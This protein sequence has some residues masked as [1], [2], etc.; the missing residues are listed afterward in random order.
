M[1]ICQGFQIL[2][3][4]AEQR[5]PAVCIIIKFAE[6]IIHGIPPNIIVNCRHS[7]DCLDFSEFLSSLF[8]KAGKGIYASFD[9]DFHLKTLRICI[10]KQD[11]GA[12]PGS[13]ANLR[14][15]QLH[16]HIHYIFQLLIGNGSIQRQRRHC[17]GN[18]RSHF[19][20]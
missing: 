3:N 4:T 11:K 2:R 16:C 19:C 9:F 6:Y 20:R 7:G 17:P 8:T 18:L 10:L 13:L 5:R 15:R 1:L 14:V 12:C